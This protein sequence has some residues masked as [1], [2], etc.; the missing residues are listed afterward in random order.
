MSVA[1]KQAHALKAM[2]NKRTMTFGTQLKYG[3]SKVCDKSKDTFTKTSLYS[4]NA[5]LPYYYKQVEK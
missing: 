1:E 2:T 3:Y 4:L 5:K